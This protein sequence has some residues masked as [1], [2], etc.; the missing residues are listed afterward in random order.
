MFNNAFWI[1]K[2]GHDRMPINEQVCFRRTLQLDSETP[3]SAQLHISGDSRFRVWVNGHFLGSGPIRSVAEHWYYDSYEIAH[4]LKTGDNC[5]A[6]QVWHYGHSNYQYIEAEAGLIAELRLGPGKGAETIGTDESWKC[7]L[8]EAYD[9]LTVKRNVN[10]GWMEIY[11]A[12]LAPGAWIEAEYDDSD[13]DQAV[14]VAS[15]DGLPWGKLHERPIYPFATEIVQPKRILEL[16]EVQPTNV[17]SLRLR[18]NFFP[19]ERDSNAK[20]FSGF[21]ASCLEVPLGAEGTISFAHTPWNGVQGRFR[22][23]GEWYKSGDKLSISPGSHLFLMEIFAVHNDGFAHMELDLE[24]VARFVHPF[25]HGEEGASFATLGPIERRHP[26][27]DGIQPIYGGV[28]KQTG[29]DREHPLLVSVGACASLADLSAYRKQFTDV[30]ADHVMWNKHIYSLVKNKQTV[31]TLPVTRDSEHLLHGYGIPSIVPTP[32]ASGDMEYTIDLG[33]MTIGDVE[34]EVDVPKG[35]IIDVYGFENR[36]EGTNQYTSGCNNA[37][38][39]IAREGR[40]T[41]RSSTR[42]GFRYLIITIRGLSQEARFYSIRLHQSHYPAAGHGGFRCSDPL[43]NEIWDISHRT[44]KLCME[45]TFVDCPTYEQVFWVGDCRVSALVDYRM[46]GSYELV[47]HCLTLVPRT[48]RL[49]NLIPALLPTDWQAAIPMWTFSWIAAIAEYTAE[50]GDLVVL[51]DLFPEV[52]ETLATYRSFLNEE[53]LLDMSAW[54]LLDWAPIDLPSIGVSTAENALLAYCH[55]LAANMAETLGQEK[56]CKEMRVFAA[57]LQRTLQT[58]LFD[59]TAGEF[60]DGIHRTGKKSSTCSI[61]THVLLFLTK[62]ISEKQRPIIEEK[63]ANPPEHWVKTGTPFFAFYLYDAW[64][65][66]GLTDRIMDGIRREWGRM[67]DFGATTTWETFA[68]FPRSHAHAWSAAPGYFLSE[69]LL[70]IE[71]K[72]DGWKRILVKPPECE[73]QW[74]EGSIPTPFGRITTSWSKRDGQ[75]VMRV[76]APKGI[77]VE[78]DPESAAK[79]R[80]ELTL[81][82]GIDHEASAAERGAERVLQ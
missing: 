32:V 7:K 69:L 73:L 56:T 2:D 70:G 31:R 44:M 23:G 15:H 34:F 67:I 57:E 39:Y 63:L 53:G 27:A 54:H 68:T 14:I 5:I 58:K 8:N 13:W 41:F 82:G 45:D 61:Q 62:A 26:I 28:E 59:E 76:Q 71:R 52:T 16:A 79:W 20:V 40:Q 81:I 21:V 42:M 12:N 17:L 47:R 55:E 65:Q 48:R 22:I 9:R 43:L 24:G 36:H 75:S 72:A 33:A 77:D 50:S 18:D 64:R 49:S 10:L 6:V 11:D 80:I 51:Q 29:L 37:Y 35:T 19:G 4:L 30:P 3:R 1:W 46:F 66:L 78:V 38:R 25:G 60:I 74:A